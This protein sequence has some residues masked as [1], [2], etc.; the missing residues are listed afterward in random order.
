MTKPRLMLYPFLLLLLTACAAPAT[1]A[2]TQTSTPEPPRATATIDNST[3]T[4]TVTPDPALASIAGRIVWLLS[5]SAETP[6]VPAVTFQLDRHNAEYLKYKS[7][8]EADGHFVFANIEP[9]TYGVG[10]YLNL[11]IKERLCDAPEFA[12]ERDLKWVHYSTWNKVDVWYDIIFSSKDIT[13][14][15]GGT[16]SL[17]FQLKCP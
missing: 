3:P 16:V 7:R 9:G 6:P 1:P 17:E 15:P 11:Q 2:P 4:L 12:A 14:Q 13:I 5:D 8:S 10:I